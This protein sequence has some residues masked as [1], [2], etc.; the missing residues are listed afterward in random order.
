MKSKFELI[1]SPE[2]LK[3]INWIKKNK[4]WQSQKQYFD[5]IERLIEAIMESP[6]GGLGK[7]EHLK[8]QLPPCWS[9]RI[10]KKDRLIYRAKENTIEIISIIGHYE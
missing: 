2:S 7:P 5:K 1:W 10:N 3:Q 8:H 4:S 6:F 9:R